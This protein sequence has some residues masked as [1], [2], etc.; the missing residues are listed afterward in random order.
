LGV[1]DTTCIWFAQ[2]KSN[3][4]RVI[5]YYENSGESL[6]HYINYCS[7]KPYIYDVSYGFWGPHDLEVREFGAGG[8]DIPK[9]R[10]EVAR[11]L[12]VNFQ[13]VPNIPIVD[14]I[15]SSRRVLRRCIFDAEKCS[16][17]LRAL[18]NYSRVWDNKNK[19]W[20]DY[21]LHNWA[22]NGSDSFRYLS[23]SIDK[24]L[25]DAEYGW[26]SPTSA[27]NVGIV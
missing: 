3:L 2:R 25:S 11:S 13:L 27:P 1:S 5:D 24:C 6:S 7:K 12:G 21:P 26:D 19:C 14:G 17:G 4:I 16:R 9:T 18:E 22:S 23:V 20:K 10:R 15:E 8:L